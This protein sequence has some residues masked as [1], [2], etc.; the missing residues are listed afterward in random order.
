[1]SDVPADAAN[2]WIERTKDGKYIVNYN[3]NIYKKLESLYERL[4]KTIDIRHISWTDS[5]ENNKSVSLVRSGRP[6]RFDFTQ[7]RVGQCTG[8]IS[9]PC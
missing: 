9:L 3:F 1:M 8:C 4:D 7:K 2:V 6:K 5:N